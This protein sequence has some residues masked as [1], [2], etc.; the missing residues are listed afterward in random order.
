MDRQSDNRDARRAAKRT[1]VI[2]ALTAAGFYLAFIWMG[3]S[4][5]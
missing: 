4:G 2:L 3:V 5:Q 1:A